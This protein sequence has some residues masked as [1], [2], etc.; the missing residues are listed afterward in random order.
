MRL[1]VVWNANAVV[2][3]LD[4]QRQ[5]DAR[6]GTGNRQ[7]HAGAERGLHDDAAAVAFVAD[8]FGGILDEIE[9]HLHQLVAIAEHGRQRRIIVLDEADAAAET[10]FRRCGGRGSARREY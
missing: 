2:F 8:G 1:Q 10:R 5:A 9:E 7:A 6:I 4:H 3:D